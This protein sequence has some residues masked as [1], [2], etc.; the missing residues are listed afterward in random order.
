MSAAEK[1]RPRGPAL[2]MRQQD[3]G[4]QPERARFVNAAQTNSNSTPQ[5]GL[6]PGRGAQETV[7]G[8][9]PGS[10]S[11]GFRR[12][13]PRDCGLLCHIRND[14]TTHARV[15]RKIGRNG[16]GDAVALLAAIALTL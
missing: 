8:G 1:S 10:A 13:L 2:T 12:C 15:T 5:H 11:P 4:E 14:G 3:T 9:L 7:G 6:G 16:A